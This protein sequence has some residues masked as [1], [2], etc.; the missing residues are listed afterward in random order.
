M[1]FDDITVNSLSLSGSG[2]D[3]T[4]AA[5]I[6]YTKN[7]MRYRTQDDAGGWHPWIEGGC[8]L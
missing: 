6:D 7:T 8:D 4:A 3:Q 2:A 1:V 5:S